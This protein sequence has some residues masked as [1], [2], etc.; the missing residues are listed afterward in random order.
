MNGGRGEE[1]EEVTC[2]CVIIA[3]LFFIANDDDSFGVSCI[4]YMMP[5]FSLSSF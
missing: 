4:H 3:V 1:E 5:V 2:E